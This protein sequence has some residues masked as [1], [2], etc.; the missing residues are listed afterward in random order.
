MKEYEYVELEC[1]N[2]RVTDSIV[3]G[4]RKI[5]DDH[6]KNGCRY[7]GYIPTKMGP[8]GKLLMLDLIFEKEN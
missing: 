5:I 7:V 4:H 3:T 6:A 8:S 1:I 2:H